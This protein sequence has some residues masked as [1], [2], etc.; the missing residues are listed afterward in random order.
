MID[1]Q[2]TTIPAIEASRDTL[3]REGVVKLDRVS[4][5]S[6]SSNVM[7]MGDE[8]SLVVPDPRGDLRDKL[9]PGWSVRFY[10]SNPRVVGDDPT[11]KVTGIITQREATSDERGG[12]SIRL[13]GADLGWH[14]THNDAPLWY[15]LRRGTLEDLA[16]ACIFPQDV[17]RKDTDPGWGFADEIRTSNERNRALKRGLRFSGA[18]R[19]GFVAS[20]ISGSPVFVQVQ[21]GQKM[22]DLLIHYA[23]RVG[24]LVGVT[25]D[26][27][28][29]FFLPDYEQ[30]PSYTISCYR[31]RDRAG[32]RNIVQ[33]AQ[34]SDTLDTIY[35]H[36]TVVGENPIYQ[37]VNVG[38]VK[39]YSPQFGKLYGRARDESLLPFRRRVTMSDGEIVVK[40]DRRA[41][42]HQMRGIF[43]AQTITYTVGGHH[44]SGSWWESD[45]MCDVHD[46]VLGIEGPH[47]V[48]AVRCQRDFGSGDITVVTLKRPNLMTEIPL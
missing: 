27:H 38:Q 19:T 20:A 48:A 41:R 42:W 8:F 16:K 10:M 12:T 45:T 26:K 35:T 24:L 13:T 4:S 29:Q 40:P 37:L 7:Q 39:Q 1:L 23:R 6:Y 18:E 17:F 25:A 22:A 5:F 9:L 33:R 34:R 15:N 47:Y 21:P 11:L 30:A 2:D 44:Q 36:V 28:L 43:D 14:L 3:F 46:D 31:D 32:E